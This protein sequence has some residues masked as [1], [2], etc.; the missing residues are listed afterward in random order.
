M[1]NPYPWPKIPN[2]SQT[3][4]SRVKQFIA[5]G[6]L[7][8][9]VISSCWR[10]YKQSLTR[11]KWM[12]LYREWK[13]RLERNRVSTSRDFHDYFLEAKCCAT[14]KF[15]GTNVGVTEDGLMLGRRLVIPNESDK[16]QSTTLKHVKEALAQVTAVK[17]VIL[18]NTHA[19]TNSGRFHCTLYGELMCNG[20]RF[21]YATRNLGGK[22]ALFGLIFRDTEVRNIGLLAYMHVFSNKVSCP[23]N[24]AC[25]DTYLG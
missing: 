12:D 6:N 13:G 18:Q 23:N 15:D 25:T 24:F 2:V 11:N 4:E 17:S 16:Y 3:V 8:Q 19:S 21:D 22:F 20:A 1:K 9:R 10:H 7:A 14:Q 5:S